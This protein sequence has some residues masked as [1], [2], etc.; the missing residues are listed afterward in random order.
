M[1]PCMSLNPFSAVSDYSSMLAKIALSTFVVALGAVALLR[2]QIADIDSF[3]KTFSVSIPLTSGFNL[4]LGTLLPA[5]LFAIASRTVKLHNVVSDILG[6]RRRFD[7]ESVLLPLAAATGTKLS[8][9]QIQD[10][11]KKRIGL[12]S[13]VFYQYVSST[14]EKAKIDKHHITMALD[15]WAWYWMLVEANVVILVASVIFFVANE[16]KWTVEL[17]ALFLMVL[18]LLI[19]LKARC[20][21]YA[22]TEIDEILRLKGSTEAIRKEFSAL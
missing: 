12:M 15:Q 1:T 18:L 9:A 16:P 7:V 11:C 2:W 13:K 4:P 14:P 17:L 22:R 5:F 21:V 20:A 8:T 19:Y 3:L 6:I 10:L